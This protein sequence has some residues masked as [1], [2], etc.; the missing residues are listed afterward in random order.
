MCVVFSWQYNKSATCKSA[1]ARHWRHKQWL[2]IYEWC[3]ILQLERELLVTRNAFCRTWYI[4][5]S[6]PITKSTMNELC[7]YDYG[8]MHYACTK[9]PYFHFRSQI[10]RHNR[11]PRPRFLIGCENYKNCKTMQFMHDHDQCH[12]CLMTVF[13]VAYAWTHWFGSNRP[14]STEHD[15]Y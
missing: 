3:Y 10:W 8:W 9:W 7:L 15:T 11:V 1:T 13:E 6:C 2:Y 14:N 5:P 4:G 12:I